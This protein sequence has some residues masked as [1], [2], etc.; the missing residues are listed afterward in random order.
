LARRLRVTTKTA[1]RRT[2]RLLRSHTI[3]FHPVT[4][5]IV[6]PGVFVNF[7]LTVRP[8]ADVPGLW[9]TLEQIDPYLVP[10]GDWEDGRL[11]TTHALPGRAD[12]S[13]I[14]FYWYCESAAQVWARVRE[15][16]RLDG[17]Y[18]VDAQ[19][20]TRVWRGSS[21]MDARLISGA[22]PTSAGAKMTA[23]P[24]SVAVPTAR[25]TSIAHR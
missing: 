14:A 6:T 25:R 22:S 19:F 20:I 10:Q 15:L 13:M 1:I 24:S 16:Q 18:R 12:R 2:N 21:W 8:G 17:V 7:Q 4:D 3:F 23:L 11:V 9:Q 5:F